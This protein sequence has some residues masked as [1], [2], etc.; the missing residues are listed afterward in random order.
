MLKMISFEDES[1]K[2]YLVNVSIEAREWVA[3]PLEDLIAVFEGADEGLAV[4]LNQF[5]G[6]EGTLTRLWY[7]EPTREATGLVREVHGEPE[8]LECISLV[9]LLKVM[10]SSA[11]TEAAWDLFYSLYEAIEHTLV[12][13]WD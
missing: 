7:D 11:G 9:T 5:Y 13:P 2:G 3:V 6:S 8:E 4:A 10:R 1:G 12:N